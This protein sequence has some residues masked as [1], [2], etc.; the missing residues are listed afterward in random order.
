MPQEMCRGLELVDGEWRINGNAV[1]QEML[2]I[3]QQLA[4]MNQAN[5]EYE[6]SKKI[7]AKYIEVNGGDKIGGVQFD[8]KV[9]VRH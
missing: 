5:L 8:I 2:L 9:R 1:G 3:S 4:H 7:Q 6:E